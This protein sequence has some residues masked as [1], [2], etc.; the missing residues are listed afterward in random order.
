MQHTILRVSPDQHR[1]YGQSVFLFDARGPRPPCL[2]ALRFLQA[3]GGT[4]LTHD[5]SGVL[6]LAFDRVV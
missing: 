4:K 5:F 6:E 2:P 1:P 3:F